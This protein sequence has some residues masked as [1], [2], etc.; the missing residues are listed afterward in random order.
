MSKYL[1]VTSGVPQGSVLGPTL[2]I[3]FINDLPNIIK[4][5]KVK[6]FADD[7][8]IYNSIND[9]NDTKCLQNTIDEMYSWTNKWL[10]KFNK[11]KCKVL[12]LGKN[13]SKYEYFI[14]NEGEKLNL[15]KQT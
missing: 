5:S 8:K 7:T 4:H 2:F 12:H 6:V 13:N 3:Y 9:V 15:K 1:D 11:E 14:G 10:L